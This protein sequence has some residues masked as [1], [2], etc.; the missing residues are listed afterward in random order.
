VPS[1]SGVSH[2]PRVR[3]TVGFLLTGTTGG[4]SIVGG[5]GASGVTFCGGGEPLQDDDWEFDATQSITLWPSKIRASFEHDALFAVAGD[6]AVRCLF[7]ASSLVRVPEPVQ[8]GTRR[9]DRP[10]RGYL[11]RPSG[12]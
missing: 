1:G 4:L 5:Q 2:R 12:G 11:A 3:A 9:G 7:W 10:P 6:V 8:L